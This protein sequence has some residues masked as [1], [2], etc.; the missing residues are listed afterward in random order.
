MGNVTP[1]FK[2][3]LPTKIVVIE[4]VDGVGKATQTQLLCS[5]LEKKGFS[6][7]DF[8]FP[9]YDRPWGRVIKK[10]LS[11]EATINPYGALVSPTVFHNNPYIKSMAYLNNFAEMFDIPSGISSALSGTYKKDFVVFDRYV[12]SMIAFAYA[13]CQCLNQDMMISHRQHDWKKVMEFINYNFL[14]VKIDLQ[15]NLYADLK[16]TKN[17]LDTRY[18]GKTVVDVHEQDNDLMH[19]VGELYRTNRNFAFEPIDSLSPDP[20]N[21]KHKPRSFF[22]NIYHNSSDIDAINCMGS[23]SELR[24]KEDIAKDVLSSVEKHFQLA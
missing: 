22:T 18:K 3:P 23:D 13:S 16:A 20:Q 24:S 10:M 19:V 4:G 15:V 8:S 14:G 21:H 5:A 7:I 6:V 9:D 17:N 1:L 11:N 2:R 12:S